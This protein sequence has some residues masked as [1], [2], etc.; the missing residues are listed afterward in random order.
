ME[1]VTI[2]LPASN[3]H[4]IHGRAGNILVDSGT[5]A[6]VPRL[7][8]ALDKLGVD[9]HRLRA[10]VLTHGHADHAGG[11]RRLVGAEVPVLIGAPDAPIVRSGR[12]PDLVCT[13]LTARVIRPFVDRPFT[14]YEPDVLIDDVTDL[15]P[16]GIPAYAVPAP[17]HTPGSL[18]IFGTRPGM[19]ALVGDLI[20]GGYLGGALAPGRPA[21]HYYSHDTGRDLRVLDALI[22]QHRPVR[23]FLGHGGPVD[24]DTVTNLVRGRHGTSTAARGIAS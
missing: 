24:T 9:P 10:V 19:P 6:A 21:R 5:E 22:G 1:I 20:R 7:R 18:A 4:L 16:Y 12:N 8:R 13:N 17:S 2:R 11:A 3:V 14:G 15:Q 23:L